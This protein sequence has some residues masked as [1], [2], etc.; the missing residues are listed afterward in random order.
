MSSITVL[1]KRLLQRFARFAQ[2]MDQK[3]VQGS[4]VGRLLD[5]EMD[6]V[7]NSLS[8]SQDILFQ[9]FDADLG[10]PDA[11]LED[12]IGN[13]GLIGTP[14]TRA[15]D[16]HRH[17][18]VIDDKG[19]VLTTDGLA[20]R[21]LPVGLNGRV[22]T[23]DAAEDTGL[24]WAPSGGSSSGTTNESLSEFSVAKAAREWWTGEIS[25]VTF[26]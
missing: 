22:L 9:L 16:D 3:F 17:P 11:P 13:V 5:E 7:A 2:L 4:E 19:D 23:A 20:L 1:P 10:P 26:R 21:R 6:R 18:A 14:S 25:A 12:V 24:R 8:Q 15:Y